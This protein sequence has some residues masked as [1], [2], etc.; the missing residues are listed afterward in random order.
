MG[1]QHFF[2]HYLNNLFDIL[3]L[4]TN[5]ITVI[6]RRPRITFTPQRLKCFFL[7]LYLL[8][9]LCALLQLHSEPTKFEG[10]IVQEMESTSCV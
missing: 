2:F 4:I 3:K 1:M 8:L 7:L 6:S 10:P 9:L 5:F